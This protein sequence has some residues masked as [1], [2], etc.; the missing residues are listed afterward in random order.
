MTCKSIQAI[1]LS[2]TK[3]MV[4]GN[5]IQ[6]LCKS[7]NTEPGSESSELGQNRYLSTFS[8]QVFEVTLRNMHEHLEIARSTKKDYKKL[9]WL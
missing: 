1:S 3:V 2:A 5:A 9:V 6:S 8:S 4:S 7:A